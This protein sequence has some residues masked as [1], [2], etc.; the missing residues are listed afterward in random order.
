MALNGDDTEISLYP[1]RSLQ[2]HMHVKYILWLM[3]IHKYNI[4][5]MYNESVTVLMLL[6]PPCDTLLIYHMVGKA[7][8]I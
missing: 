6:Y 7:Y 3:Q 5:L 2:L 4:P 1:C 8:R